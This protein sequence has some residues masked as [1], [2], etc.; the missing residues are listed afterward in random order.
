MRYPVCPRCRKVVPWK[1]S[2]LDRAFACPGCGAW[3]ASSRAY[4]ISLNV[5]TL[6]IAAALLYRLGL[7]GWWLP[8]ATIML[9]Y[10]VLFLVVGV[11]R[12]NRP[13][14]LRE[15]TDPRGGMVLGISLEITSDGDKLQRDEQNGSR[16]P[17]GS[18]E[19]DGSRSAK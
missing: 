17:P 1:D 5:I 10:P 8:V 4:T 2:H 3:L 14:R 11:A 12:A 16:R 6:V 19:S 13:P 15:T 7:R 9:F 18:P